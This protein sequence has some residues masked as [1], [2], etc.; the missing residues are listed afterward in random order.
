MMSK[1]LLILG[2]KSDLHVAEKAITVLKKFDVQYEIHVASA[3]RTPKRVEEIITKTDADVMIAIAGLAAALPG[4]VAS[5]TVKPVVGVPV[6]G[7]VNLDSILSIVQMPPGIP[8]A[9]VGLDRGDNAA[10]L[11][12]QIIAVADKK[13]TKKLEEYRQEMADKIMKDSEEVKVQCSM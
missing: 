8:V 3:H 9:T 10:M 13:I 2:S 4:S 5:L 12:L 1:V 6:S 7:A 11:A